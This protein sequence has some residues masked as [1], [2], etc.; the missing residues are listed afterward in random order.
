[1]A[2]NGKL[3]PII[4]RDEGALL[5]SP[6]LEAINKRHSSEIRR[7]IQSNSRFF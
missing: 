7:T 6:F 5:A 3:D 1:M 2:R 4:G